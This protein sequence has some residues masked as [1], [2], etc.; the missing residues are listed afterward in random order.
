MEF[1]QGTIDMLIL[2]TL[3][4]GEL[5]GYGIAQF[6]RQTSRETLLLEAGSLYPALQRLELQKLITAKWQ[7]SDTG[8]R[9]RFYKLTNAGRQRLAA[10][11]SRWEEFVNSIGLVLHPAEGNEMNAVADEVKVCCCLGSG[12]GE[13]RC[14]M[15][16]CSRIWR[17]RKRKHGAAD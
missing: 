14:W 4:Q 10:S 6:I 1:L 13:S 3:L 12:V 7:T 15:R 11:M 2:R 17:W 8:R 5:H 9:A 16:R